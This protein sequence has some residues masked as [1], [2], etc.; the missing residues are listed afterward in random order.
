MQNGLARTFELAMYFFRNST[1]R[2][3]TFSVASLFL[4]MLALPAVAQSTHQKYLEYLNSAE[5]AEATHQ[6]PAAEEDFALAVKESDNPGFTL[7]E[8]L[9]SNAKLAKIYV[10]QGKLQLA[11]PA[12][13]RA[14]SVALDLVKKGR[15]DEATLVWIEDLADAYQGLRSID[16]M[17]KCLEIHR[18]FSPDHRSVP[19]VEE[20][21]AA[22]YFHLRKYKE[23][24]PL[25]DD[26]VRRFALSKGRGSLT[27]PKAKI[28]DAEIKMQLRKYG[29]AEEQ[30]KQAIILLQDPLSKSPDLL[31][32]AD[33]ILGTICAQQK[34]YGKA[35]ESLT[36][37]LKLRQTA[38]SEDSVADICVQLCRVYLAQNKAAKAEEFGRKALTMRTAR[39]GFETVADIDLMK[40]LAAACK[41]NGH[42]S[43]AAELEA[44]IK[45]LQ[46]K[47]HKHG[48][49]K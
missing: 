34:K 47:A 39:L 23:A 17:Q 28:E 8:Q 16:S 40:D 14:K 7:M 29:E 38:K 49:N 44:R 41:R 11:E 13:Q 43:Q 4:V 33:L 19:N 15:G 21:L 12:Y 3:R 30:C 22:Y 9:E 45:A 1:F 42:A 10:I 2:N 46:E 35:E 32:K 24:E 36:Q 5:R 25:A 6:Y 27:A 20:Q 18:T 31:S 26:A 37:S 48:T